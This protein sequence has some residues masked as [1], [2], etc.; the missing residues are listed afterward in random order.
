MK[1]TL[2][3]SFLSLLV[4][5]FIMRWQGQ[6]LITPSSSIGILDLEFAKTT[7]RLNQLLLFWNYN[8]IALNIY[9]DFLLIAAYTWFFISSCVYLK[10]KLPLVN[11]SDRFISMAVAAALFDV[12]ENLVMLFII[13]GRFNPS[14][15]LQV[16]FYCALAKFIL[17]GM[18]LLYILIMLPVAIL[19]RRKWEL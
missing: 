11:W 10:H 13:N 17:A 6:S 19:K 8:D 14:F 3:F 15:S 4:M 5:I 16:V 7:V 18:V 2:L 12:C 1:R 9:L